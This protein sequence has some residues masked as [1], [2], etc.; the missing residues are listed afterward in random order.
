MLVAGPN[1]L[2]ALLTSLRMGFRS[3]T[4]EKKSAEVLRLLSEVR[5][6]FDKYEESVEIVRRRLE[7]T[8]DSLDQMDVRARK[9]H[10]ALRNLDQQ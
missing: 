7:Q 1:T 4:L 5:A 2:A 6:E 8:R 9:L 10:K 3:V